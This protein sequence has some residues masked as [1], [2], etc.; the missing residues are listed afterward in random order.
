MDLKIASA[1]ELGGTGVSH[2][3]AEF[4]LGQMNAK[5][6]NGRNPRFCRWASTMTRLRAPMF[7]PL[8][9]QDGECVL[10]FMGLFP[11]NA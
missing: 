7:R 6:R 10:E 3:L 1:Q 4:V 2:V 11:R 5:E 9:A 8:V